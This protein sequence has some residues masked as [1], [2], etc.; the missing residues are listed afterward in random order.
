MIYNLVYLLI[1][2]TIRVLLI[3]AIIHGLRV[4]HQPPSHC[5]I[6]TGTH[7]LKLVLICSNNNSSINSNSIDR[8]S[9]SRPLQRRPTARRPHLVMLTQWVHCLWAQQM[10]QVKCTHQQSHHAPDC[11]TPSQCFTKWVFGTKNWTKN[12]SR[13]TVTMWTIP[14]RTCSALIEPDSKEVDQVNNMWSRS[15][16]HIPQ[17]PQSRSLTKVQFIQILYQHMLILFV[18]FLW[19]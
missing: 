15:N 5:L 3:L 10:V 8:K 14:S 12:Y 1:F 16:P 2:I 13:R 11:Q 9:F 4:R 19:I 6:A 7:G 17:V 18:H